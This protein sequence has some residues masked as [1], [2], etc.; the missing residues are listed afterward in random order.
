M[1]SSDPRLPLTD[2]APKFVTVTIEWIPPS[3]ST[4]GLIEVSDTAS[5]FDRRNVPAIWH[6]GHR[7]GLSF[8]PGTGNMSQMMPVPAFWEVAVDD[9][10]IGT[11]KSDT[12]SLQK[13]ATDA[14]ALAHSRG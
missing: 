8:F 10:V 5:A 2:R 7:I 1:H 4:I 9:V 12:V 11:L 3:D 14:V 6:R 13:L